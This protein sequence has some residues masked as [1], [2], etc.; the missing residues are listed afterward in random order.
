LKAIHGKEGPWLQRITHKE[1]NGEDVDEKTD[2]DE[3]HKDN[4]FPASS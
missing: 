2:R 4:H 3:Q 1:Y